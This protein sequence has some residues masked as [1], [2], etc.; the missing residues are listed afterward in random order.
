MAIK[1]ARLKLLDGC[2]LNYL[3]AG[4]GEPLVF[5]PGWSQSAAQFC[6]QLDDL[7]DRFHVI[8]LDLRGHGESDKPT[9]GYRMH[10]LARDVREVLARLGFDSVTLAGHSM[11][12]SVIWC[13]LDL[14]GPERLNRAIFI[15][16]GA[17]NVHHPSWSDDERLKAG[18]IFTAQSLHDTAVALAGPEGVQTTENFVRTAFFTKAYPADRLAWVIA[19]NLK[20]PRALAGKLLLNHCMQDW[21]DVIPTI[22]LPTLVVGGAASLFDPRSQ[23]W[24]A[25]QI[26]G[27]RVE[28]FPADEGGSHFMFLENPKRF[29]A[30]VRTFMT[31]R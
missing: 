14:F 3:E 21:R 5:I 1:Q 20:M 31:E 30:L 22:C 24:I 19:E 8:A 13:Y 25:D 6:A 7:S 16:Q 9:T 27:A 15:D 23:T 26:P 28:I 11:G 12:S 18:A 4:R 2:A 29:N 17:C 10:R